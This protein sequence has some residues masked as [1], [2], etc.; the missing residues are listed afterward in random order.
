MAI[1]RPVAI[2]SLNGNMLLLQVVQDNPHGAG[3]ALKG[4]TEALE[5]LQHQQ[6]EQRAKLINRQKTSP[7]SNVVNVTVSLPA[8][9]KASRQA[10]RAQSPVNASSCDGSGIR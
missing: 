4:L 2:S 6:T 8:S 10:S 9:R 7:D 1:Q 5:T 3:E